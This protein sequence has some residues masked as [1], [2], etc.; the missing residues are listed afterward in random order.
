MPDGTKAAVF[1]LNNYLADPL[2]SWAS[3]QKE[4]V[5]AFNS[6]LSD[7]GRRK[8]EKQCQGQQQLPSTLCSVCKGDLTKYNSKPVPCP[9]PGCAA[10]MHSKCIRK[11]SCPFFLTGTRKRS[12]G[13]TSFLSIEDETPSPPAQPS[14]QADSI[15]HLQEVSSSV[16]HVP[17]PVPLNPQPSHLPQASLAPFQQPTTT[18]SF[19]T[20]AFPGPVLSTFT[21]NPSAAPITFSSNSNPTSQVAKSISAP[22]NKRSKPTPSPET[23]QIEFINKEL[24]IAKTKISTLENDIKRKDDTPKLQEERIKSLENAAI[25]SMFNQYLPQSQPP[26]TDQACP[27]SQMV[28]KLMSEMSM[29]R[30]QVGVLQELIT[31]NLFHSAQAPSSPVNPAPN[32]DS[33]DHTEHVEVPASGS[34][35][36]MESTQTETNAANADLQGEK[37]ASVSGK[38]SEKVK[39]NKQRHSKPTPMLIK[40]KVSMQ[41][42]LSSTVWDHGPTMSFKQVGKNSNNSATKSGRHPSKVAAKPRQQSKRSENVRDTSN[43]QVRASNNSTQG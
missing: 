25:S 3:E 14:A 7:F 33:A 38:R 39:L 9:N 15:L 40:P 35:S 13:M 22:R 37:P 2:K 23:V 26:S 18:V 1:I 12:I 20:A 31:E 5:A 16:P 42:W 6:A 29:L 32:I 4:S 43:Q 30:G 21:L 11:H 8:A 34:G 36:N 28:E 24:I 10:R 27:S 41:P 17:V 19:T